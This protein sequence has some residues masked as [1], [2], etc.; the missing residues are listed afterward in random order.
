MLLT[1][2][3]YAFFGYYAQLSDFMLLQGVTKRCRLSYLTNIA[4]E[5]ERRVGGGGVLVTGSQRMSMAVH[6]EPK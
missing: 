3:V 2:S 5:F 1:V 4:L 6:M